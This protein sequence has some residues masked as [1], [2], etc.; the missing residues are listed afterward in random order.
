MC[1]NWM[2]TIVY[3]VHLF[4][5]LILLLVFFAT[6]CRSLNAIVQL[7]YKP[8]QGNQKKKKK[9]KT[10]QKNKTKTSKK[11]NKVR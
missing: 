9:K 1:S 2:I 6:R 3:G 10:G 11:L 4:R 7:K 8:N 5:L